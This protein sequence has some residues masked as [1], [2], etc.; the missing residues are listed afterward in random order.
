MKQMNKRYTFDDLRDIMKKLRSSCPWDKVQTHET[1][2]PYLIE[3]CYEAIDAVDHKDFDNLKEE[4]GDVLLQIV[5]HSE[6]AGENNHFTIEDVIHTVC[7]KMISRHTHIFGSDVAETSAEVLNTWEKNKNVEKGYT[8]VTQSLKSVPKSMPALNRAYKIGAYASKAGM[9]FPA[10]EDALK[11]VYEELS[12]LENKLSNNG[13][14]SNI[15]DELGDI[16]FS[17]INI[18]RFLNINPEFSLTKSVETF[19]NRFEYVENTAIANDKQ[20]HDMPLYE[21]DLLWQKAKQHML[22]NESGK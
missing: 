18:A 20:I 8:T 14:F 11:K 3:E 1:L 17:V 6:I 9:D 2:K 7:A 21:L 4:L 13:I 12:E 10:V 16:L 15:S 22:A 19:I 5:F